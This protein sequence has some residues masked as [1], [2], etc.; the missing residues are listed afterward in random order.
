MAIR[1]AYAAAIR[2]HPPDRDAGAFRRIRDAYEYLSQTEARVLG[3]LAEDLDEEERSYQAYTAG[4]TTTVEPDA[5]APSTTDA[6]AAPSPGSVFFDVPTDSDDKRPVAIVDPEDAEP[7]AGEPETEPSISE[8]SSNFSSESFDEQTEPAVSAW[9]EELRASLDHWLSG[10]PE[11]HKLHIRPLLA[12]AWQEARVNWALRTE[13]MRVLDEE[14]SIRKRALIA[15]VAPRGITMEG[16]DE[17]DIG[18]LDWVARAFARAGMLGMLKGLAELVLARSETLESPTAP[19]DLSQLALACAIQQPDCAEQLLDAAYSIAPPAWRRRQDR[20]GIEAL[21]KAGRAAAKWRPEARAQFAWILE[22]GGVPDGMG[23]GAFEPLVG[24]LQNE[25]RQSVP[26]RLLQEHAPA[27]MGRVHMR[28][29]AAS[30]RRLDREHVGR[31]K[32]DA[33]GF[34]IWTLVLVVLFIGR[35]CNRQGSPGSDDYKQTKSEVERMLDEMR[36]RR[37]EMWDRLDEEE[38]ESERPSPQRT[39]WERLESERR[40]SERSNGDGAHDDDR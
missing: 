17:G 26:T 13:M 32:K 28:R 31:E 5:E 9:G 29:V 12:T 22:C 18:L 38:R 40:E 4:A 16:L 11:Q 30:R 3:W 8:R 35:A 21:L 25:S 14:F 27:I 20:A 1:R 2:A 36:E 37:H 10:T 19:D 23:V 6:T 34:P 15:S 7:S 39:M 33:G 24:A